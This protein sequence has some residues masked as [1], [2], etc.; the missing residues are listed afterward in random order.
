MPAYHH[1]KLA[2][3]PSMLYGLRRLKNWSLQSQKLKSVNAGSLCANTLLETVR[4]DAIMETITRNQ[5]AVS[6]SA[7]FPLEIWTN[8]ITQLIYSHLPKDHDQKSHMESREYRRR[9]IYVWRACRGVSCQFKA[10][11]EAAFVQ[12][13]LLDYPHPK[14]HLSIW[15]PTVFMGEIVDDF[16]DRLIL[17]YD[18]LLPPPPGTSEEVRAAWKMPASEVDLWTRVPQAWLNGARHDNLEDN[19]VRYRYCCGSAHSFE[20]FI[21]RDWVTI[22]DLRVHEDGCRV[23]FPLITMLNTYFVGYWKSSRAGGGGKGF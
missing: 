6:A 23:S 10:A 13:L 7:R 12:T 3:A 8:I 18:R 15:R 16:V 5:S 11:T 22:P 4:F 1:R 17:P 2:R 9:I 14:I 21:F 20:L 19:T